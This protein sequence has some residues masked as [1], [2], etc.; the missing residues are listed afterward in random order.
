MSFWSIRQGGSTCALIPAESGESRD[1]A[2]LSIK[3][4]VACRIPHD[5]FTRKATRQ[6]SR[7]PRTPSWS[8][9]DLPRTSQALPWNF[10]GVW[11]VSDSERLLGNL[12]KSRWRRAATVPKQATASSSRAS[13]IP[14]ADQWLFFRPGIRG[15]CQ[16]GGVTSPRMGSR[17]HV[18][19][20]TPAPAQTNRCCLLPSR[21]PSPLPPPP[22]ENVLFLGLLA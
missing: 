15:G 14:S 22:V 16:V 21:G 3:Y 19:R 18:T 4:Q 11:S 12:Q 17:P 8:G 20:I 1:G 6:R 13:V 9:V 7:N 10:C 5:F 2:V